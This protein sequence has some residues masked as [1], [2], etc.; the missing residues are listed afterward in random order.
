MEHG[1]IYDLLDK[2]IAERRNSV[3]LEKKIKFA[4]KMR[5]VG[6]GIGLLA[7]VLIIVWFGWKFVIVISL[8][9]WANNISQKYSK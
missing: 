9:L 6:M 1:S 2:V 8:T 3:D 4:K 7:L 5:L